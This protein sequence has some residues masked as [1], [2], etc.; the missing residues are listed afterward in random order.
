MLDQVALAALNHLLQDASWARERL[1]PFSGRSARLSLAPFHLDFTIAP[2][3]TVAA[4]EPIN[5]PD[6]QIDLP[7]E[8]PF[9]VLR[10]TEAISKATRVSGSVEFADALGFVLRNLSWDFE[11]DLSKLTGDIAAHRIAAMLRSFGAWQGR[12]R[13]SLMENWADYLTDEQPTLVNHREL[14]GFSNSIGQLGED[15]ARID[16]RIQ[17]LST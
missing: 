1:A 14:G 12:A 4:S 15:L 6:V 17:Q 5:D 13:Q 2:G 16:L 9:L 11:E 8:T 10:G 3:G 7:V